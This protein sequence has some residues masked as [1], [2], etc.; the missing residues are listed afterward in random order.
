MIIR[1]NEN[2]FN[3]F[4]LFES[5]NSKRAH[6]KTREILGQHFDDDPNSEFIIKFEETLLKKY[7]GEGKNVDWFIVLE[8][9]ITMWLLQSPGPL[10]EKYIDY[11]FKKATTF[12]KPSEYIAKVRPIENF[13]ELKQFVD[14]QMAE[15]RAKEREEM[16]KMG[17]NLNKNYEVLG[18]LSYEEAQKYGKYSGLEFGSS[19]R[20]C[21]T[22]N[23]STWNSSNYSDNG[24]N[25]CFLLLRNDWKT[26]SSTHDGSQQYNGLPEPLNEY[27]GYDDYGLSMIFVWITPEGELHECNTRWNHGADYAPGHGVD[28]AM[29]ELDIAKLMGAPFE[30]IFKVETIEQ[31]DAYLNHLLES[32][33]R[34][35]GGDLNAVF[36]DIGDT[37]GENIFVRYNNRWNLLDGATRSKLLLPV[38]FDG[39]IQEVE[40]SMFVLY[41]HKPNVITKEGRYLWNRP[42]KEW[43]DVI[44]VSDSPYLVVKKNRKFN[45]LNRETGNLLY[46]G[47]WFDGIDKTRWKKFKL[48]LAYCPVWVGTGNDKRYNLLSVKG[49]LLWPASI[50]E[51][52]DECWIFEEYNEYLVV[53]IKGQMNIV[54]THGN[55]VYRKP[56]NEWFNYIEGNPFNH[57]G[58]PFAF[59]GMKLGEE[60]SP[61]TGRPR[62]K[63]KYNLLRK[64]GTLVYNETPENWITS[65][66]GDD[67]DFFGRDC[68]YCRIRNDEGKYNL[69]NTNG[70]ISWNGNE[71]FDT[72]SPPSKYGVC[73]V[74]KHTSDG[75]YYNVLIGNKG[76]LASDNW[77]KYASKAPGG[78]QLS[79]TPNPYAD[80]LGVINVSYKGEITTE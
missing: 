44:S 16:K 19:G 17:I 49:D 8:P 18:P 76:T 32:K 70:Q 2:R 62:D 77:F 36:D 5:K 40:D 54:D 38:W 78:F 80:S 1:L 73:L 69:I 47:E 51:W 31:K 58:L 26:V 59:V 42:V 66:L 45:F 33:L 15:D 29:T 7:F 28:A 21:Y 60:E 41:K 30:Q 46:D 37:F 63:Y 3:K 72:I 6:Q 50:D 48:T 9:N 10:F 68:N 14:P 24:K 35:A 61:M 43:F 25:S 34:G 13:E 67:L 74:K 39:I 4:F 55:F 53:G 27:N 52:F 56:V 20:I 22:Q 11:V 71:W 65:F 57:S 12:K 75:S 23:M 64:D 79:N